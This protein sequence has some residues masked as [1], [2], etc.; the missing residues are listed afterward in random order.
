[1]VEVVDGLRVAGDA[2]IVRIRPGALAQQG[3]D[4]DSVAAQIEALVGG[5]AATRIR[6]GEQLLDVRVRAPAD[7][8]A[9][10]RAD[11]AAAAGRARTATA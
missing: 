7:I 2:L 3:L 4:A 11:R 1:M 5:T 6:A 8:R 10:R 9:A